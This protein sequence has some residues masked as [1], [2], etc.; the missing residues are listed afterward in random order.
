[1]CLH[2]QLSRFI[3]VSAEE[4]ADLAL[5]LRCLETE[6][7]VFT[8]EN[9]LVHMSA[10]GWI[11]NP[12]RTQVLMAYHNLYQSWAWL[13]GH[14]DGDENLLRVALR[15]A[16]EES[17]L[18]HVR[19]VLEDIFSVEVLPVL[20]H[21][22]RGRYVSSHIHLNMTYLLE[23]DDGQAVRAKPDENSGVRWFP[24]DEAVAASSEEWMRDHVYQKLNGKLRAGGLTK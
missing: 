8:R 17:G 7:A 2:A 13:G 6:P 11:V 9:P 15:E 23:A 16:Q 4:S 24:L 1:M 10:S 14:A 19:P 22:K 3:P 18:R 12:D 21:W 5:I 20:G